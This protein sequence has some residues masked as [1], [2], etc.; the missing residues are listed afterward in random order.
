LVKK[1]MGAPEVLGFT[2]KVGKRWQKE[3]INR[4]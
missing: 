4:V 3:A 1:W 2:I